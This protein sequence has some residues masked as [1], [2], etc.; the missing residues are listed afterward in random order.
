MVVVKHMV[1]LNVND[2]LS[3]M[4][5]VPVNPASQSHTNEPSVLWHCACSLHGCGVTSSAH[6]S[7]SSHSLRTV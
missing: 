5:P 3:Q 2:V 4:T 7:T 6:S 1:L